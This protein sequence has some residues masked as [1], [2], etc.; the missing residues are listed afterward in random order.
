MHI[1]CLMVLIYID[2]LEYIHIHIYEQTLH[3][4]CLMVLIYIDVH[5][6]LFLGKKSQF[7]FIKKNGNHIHHMHTTHYIY[8]C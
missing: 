8:I 1:W 4:W 5:E 7:L 2:V 3:I 6:F